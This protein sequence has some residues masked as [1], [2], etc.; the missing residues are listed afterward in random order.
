MMTRKMTLVLGVI[1]N[2]T[3]GWKLRSVPVALLSP[4]PMSQFP[5]NGTLMRLD[6]G[7]CVS[8]AN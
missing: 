4:M 7:F 6:T 5:W 3:T 2:G 1:P 8:F